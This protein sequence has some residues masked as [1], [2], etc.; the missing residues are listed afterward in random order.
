M[1]Y[2]A[3]CIF[4]YVCCVFPLHSTSHNHTTFAQIKFHFPFQK[5]NYILTAF[6]VHNPSNLGANLPTNLST[7]TS[8]SIKITTPLAR[9][10]ARILSFHYIHVLCNQLFIQMT[11]NTL[12]HN[13][14]DQP[15]WGDCIKNL[16]KFM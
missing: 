1:P 4:C 10:P 6:P 9:P 3:N 13:L 7:F 2:F 16:T 5:Q 14:L 12:H 15:T 11:V 8:K